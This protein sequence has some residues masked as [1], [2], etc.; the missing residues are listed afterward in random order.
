MVCVCV[1]QSGHVGV[2][3]V[4]GDIYVDSPSVAGIY[5][6]LIVQVFYVCA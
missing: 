3:C 4:S 2:G 1:L 5:L 6:C